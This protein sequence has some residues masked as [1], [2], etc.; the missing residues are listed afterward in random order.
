MAIMKKKICCFEAWGLF[1]RCLLVM[2]TVNLAG[3]Q[4]V[5]ADNKICCPSGKHDK[6]LETWAIHTRLDLPG[7]KESL[8][9][10][11]FFVSGVLYFFKGNLGHIFWL[12]TST[13]EYMYES[14]IFI[15]PFEQVKH[16]NTALNQKF[17]K[18]TIKYNK[19]NNT[20]DVNADFSKFHIKMKLFPEKEMLW[21]DQIFDWHQKDKLFDWYMLPRVRVEAEINSVY[22]I[23]T[24]GN[25]HFQHFWG[26]EVFENGDF[27]VALL[28]SGYDVIINAITPPFK[29]EPGLPGNYIMVLPPKGDNYKLTSFDYTVKQWWQSKRTKKKYPVSISVKTADGKLSFDINVFKKDQTAKLITVEKWFGYTNIEGVIAGVPQKGWAFM[30]TIGTD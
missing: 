17:K 2:I 8:Y 28:D 4:L 24:T 25:G 3:I 19:E 16:D 30:S 13:E 23:N 15:P 20:I 9:V 29:E 12:D 11:M 22:K 1:V 10:G 6:D 27:I 7:K 18:S 21:L 26:D 5:Y 14:D